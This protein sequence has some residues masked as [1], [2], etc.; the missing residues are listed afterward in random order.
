MNMNLKKQIAMEMV[1]IRE[2]ST[3]HGKNVKLAGAVIDHFL[4]VNAANTEERESEVFIL[5]ILG[6]L[7]REEVERLIELE[8]SFNTVA[9]VP[10]KEIAQTW[11]VQSPSV[12]SAIRELKKN[13]TFLECEI[14]GLDFAVKDEKDRVW[15][16]PDYIE[17]IGKFARVAA[18]P[19]GSSRTT[20]SRP[21]LD[22]YDGNHSG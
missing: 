16:H 8:K 22:N 3:L 11:R 5:P 21:T 9:R 17:L 1:S 13:Q 19:G 15:V 14:L 6:E 2:I 10:V 4:K 7:I 18:R 20:T 12:I